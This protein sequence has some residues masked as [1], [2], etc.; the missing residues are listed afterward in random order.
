MDRRWIADDSAI[1]RAR[2]AADRNARDEQRRARDVPLPPRKSILLSPGADISRAF[3]GISFDEAFTELTALVWA[4]LL[5]SFRPRRFSF[6]SNGA[7]AR[8]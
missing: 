4:H 6:F 8:A 1:N 3:D 5:R 7:R 2:S